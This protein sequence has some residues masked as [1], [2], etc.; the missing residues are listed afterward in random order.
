MLNDMSIRL[1]LLVA[2]LMA[3]NFTGRLIKWYYGGLIPTRKIRVC[4]RFGGVQPKISAMLF[5][6]MYE[7][8][9]YRLLKKYLPQ[10]VNVLECGASL[11]FMS[12]HIS[13]K[14]NSS[15]SIVSIEANEKMIPNIKQTLISNGCKNVTVRHSAIDYWNTGEVQFNI[16]TDSLG[17]RVG[18]ASTNAALV[19]ALTLSELLD[20]LKWE[21]F[22]LVSDIEG[23]ELGFLL[24]DQRALTRCEMLII[25]LHQVSH[26]G[27][28]FAINDLIE[29]I[30][31]KHGFEL[32][33]QDGAVAAFRRKI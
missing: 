32:L 28:Q 10:D 9:E 21:R 22:S 6:N 2:N 16:S 8:A 19:K 20:D 17:S 12:T 1:K 23:A 7:S 33:E 26:S 3:N 15:T 13:R 24:N 30:K 27:L 18:E 11:G 31:G 5:W 14:V 29:L 4:T 25:E